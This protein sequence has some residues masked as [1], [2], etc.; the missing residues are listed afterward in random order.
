MALAQAK[1]Y[2]SHASIT[3]QEIQ[4]VLH[5]C[6]CD[7][8]GICPNSGVKVLQALFFQPHS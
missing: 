1:H 7:A 6:L 4:N 2:S 8:Q 5:R 3:M